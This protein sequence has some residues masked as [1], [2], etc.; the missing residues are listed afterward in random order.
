MKSL[1]VADCFVVSGSPSMVYW[2]LLCSSRQDN[3][4][5]DTFRTCSQMEMSL[6]LPDSWFLLGTAVY[7]FLI[8]HGATQKHRWE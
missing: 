2:F 1:L 6:H 8:H 5:L 4:V 3:Q 7:C